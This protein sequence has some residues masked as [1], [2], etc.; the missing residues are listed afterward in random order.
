MSNTMETATVSINVRHRREDYT[1]QEKAILIDKFK[2]ACRWLTSFFKEVV[3]PAKGDQLIDFEQFLKVGGLKDF[4]SYFNYTSI[5]SLGF[6]PAN[7]I[8]ISCGEGTVGTFVH[9]GVTEGRSF[10]VPVFKSDTPLTDNNYRGPRS[11]NYQLV[12]YRVAYKDKTKRENAEEASKNLAK[13]L[14]TFYI[15][16]VGSLVNSPNGIGVF[17]SSFLNMYYFYHNYL[18]YLNIYVTELEFNNPNTNN[19]MT[20]VVWESRDFILKLL[21]NEIDVERFYFDTDAYIKDL[22]ALTRAAAIK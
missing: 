18:K 2:I 9:N 1:E 15:F 16:R 5:A 20:Q 14:L 17:T 22:K 13:L 11:N 19:E 10:Y 21:Q 6:F 12:N 8:N 4:L 3:T 7:G